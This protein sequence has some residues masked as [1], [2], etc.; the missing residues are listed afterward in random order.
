M[1][2]TI[3][4]NGTTFEFDI[5]D[6]ST[7]DAAARKAAVWNG[8]ESVDGDDLADDDFATYE[9]AAAKSVGINGQ[10]MFKQISPK[11]AW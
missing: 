3:T 11:P 7:M 10:F 2:A 4:R 6:R 1:K 9:K 5:L 8:Y